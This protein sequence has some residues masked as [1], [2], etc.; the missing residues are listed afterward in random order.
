MGDMN[1]TGNLRKHVKSCW[2]KE[3]LDAADAKES[4]SDARAAVSTYWQTQDIKVAFGNIGK[5]TVTF[6]MCHHPRQ[7]RK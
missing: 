7:G 4:A 1:L 2:G 6:S 5:K 3:A